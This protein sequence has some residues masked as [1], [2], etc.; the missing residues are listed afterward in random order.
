MLSCHRLSI[1]AFKIEENFSLFSSESPQSIGLLG[2][3]P[4]LR[5]QQED[6]GNTGDIHKL[7]NWLSEAL[8]NARH[9]DGFLTETVNKALGLSSSGAYEELKQK[10]DYELNSTLDKKESEQPACTKIENVHFKDAQS[11]LLEVDAASVK[12]PP[13]LSS[14]EVGINHKLHC[15]V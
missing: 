12:Y 11:P 7:Y 2:Q 14:S 10:C 4:N 15:K 8:A 13:L 1:L 6:S 9:S 3:D 5:V